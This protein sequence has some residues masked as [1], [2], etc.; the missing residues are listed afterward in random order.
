MTRLDDWTQA[1][2]AELGLDQQDDAL[3]TVLN[4]A[5]DVAHK[6]DRPAAPVT[7]FYLGMAV[8]QGQPLAE[9]T[10]KAQQLAEGWPAPPDS[11][12]S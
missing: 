7:A 3:R 6:V 4:M 8:G 1:L 9:V 12:G 11:A 10:A 5:R 2:C